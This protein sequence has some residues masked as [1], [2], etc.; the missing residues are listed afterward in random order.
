MPLGISVISHTEIYSGAIDDMDV[1][2]K[3][4]EVGTAGSNLPVNARRE[5]YRNL[6]SRRI[7]DAGA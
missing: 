6:R 2:W 7:A 5:I 4:E 1:G 3:L